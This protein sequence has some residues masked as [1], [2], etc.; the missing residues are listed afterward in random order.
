MTD[1][2]GSLKP[3]HFLSLPLNHV[4]FL[5]I[6]STH[7]NAPKRQVRPL[8]LIET[9]WSTFSFY[10]CF[11]NFLPSVPMYRTSR[12]CTTNRRTP[13]MIVIEFSHKYAAIVTATSQQPFSSAACA[14]LLGIPCGLI[15]TRHRVFALSSC[16]SLS[17]A[18]A[19][20]YVIRSPRCVKRYSW[21]AGLASLHSN[22][23]PRF[24]KGYPYPEG[25]RAF[26]PYHV[27][28]RDTYLTSAPN[29]IRRSIKKQRVLRR[30]KEI[31]RGEKRREEKKKKALARRESL[32][33]RVA[34]HTYVHALR[35]R[36]LRK[37]SS[38]TSSYG[39]QGRSKPSL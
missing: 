23:L 1:C 24:Q 32:A 35:E 14:S 5:S 19:F 25:C 15:T 36:L 33:D 2:C 20:G 27:S 31:R 12:I 39:A 18:I 26:G 6:P 11:A 30:K 37:S 16:C 8:R 10:Q 13:V 21:E 28:L 38:D 7:S 9:Y 3:Q 4:A 34:W 17:R 29:F 22:T